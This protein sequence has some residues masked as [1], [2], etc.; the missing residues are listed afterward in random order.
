MVRPQDLRRLDGQNIKFTIMISTNLTVK[1]LEKN[2][3]VYEY[4]EPMQTHQYMFFFNQLE[5]EIEITA[6]M[7]SQNPARNSIKI[8]LL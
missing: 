7:L 6:N 1:H 5:Q 2:S 4:L 3:V 8:F